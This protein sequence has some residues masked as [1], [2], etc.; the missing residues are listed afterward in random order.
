MILVNL[1]DVEDLKE[2]EELF[3]NSNR[4]EKRI[5]SETSEEEIYEEE[6]ISEKEKIEDEEEAENL[7]QLGKYASI[8]LRYLQECRRPRPCRA[9][10]RS[11]SSTRRKGCRPAR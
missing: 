2:F 5:D 1:D 7:S 6:E 11:W 9:I 4:L 8:R 10:R 3:D